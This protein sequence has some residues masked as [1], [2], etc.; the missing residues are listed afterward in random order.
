MESVPGRG[1]RAQAHRMLWRHAAC[2]WYPVCGIQ[3]FQ[4]SNTMSQLTGA[5]RKFLR[6]MA[7]GLEALIIVGKQGASDSL[8]RATSAEL[9]AH[10][11]IK[12]RFNEHKD[13]KD[14]L[15]EKIA[16]GTGAEIVGRIGHVVML[17]R[18]H[19]DPE[20]RTIKLS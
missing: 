19:P 8:I 11:L 18:Q 17:Y 2:F 9:E 1:A 10:E 20:K 3:L 5:Q 16:E 7:N 4:E 12:V 13:E 6:G 14:A 15:T